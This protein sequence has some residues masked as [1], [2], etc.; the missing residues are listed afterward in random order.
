[1]D[2]LSLFS[3]HFF[4]VVSPKQRTTCVYLSFSQVS[5]LVSLVKMCLSIQNQYNNTPPFSPVK[6]HYPLAESDPFLNEF[7]YP[8]VVSR[9]SQNVFAI[10]HS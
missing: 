2:V 9:P 6:L 10:L 4:R 3:C 5:S 8:I 7:K 1:M